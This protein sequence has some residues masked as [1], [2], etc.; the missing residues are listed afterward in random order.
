MDQAWDWEP[1]EMGYDVF[2][3]TDLLC[4]SFPI[5]MRIMILSY[6]CEALSDKV[7]IFFCKSKY[8]Y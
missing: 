2:S 1:G 5:I 6:L 7:Y 8:Y 4:L 3:A